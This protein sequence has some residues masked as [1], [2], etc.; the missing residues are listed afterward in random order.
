MEPVA[1]MGCRDEEA[2]EDDGWSCAQDDLQEAVD[3][4]GEVAGSV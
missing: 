2:A 3:G 4:L 1:I